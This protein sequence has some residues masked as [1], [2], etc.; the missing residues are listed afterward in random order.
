MTT[1]TVFV[2]PLVM[3]HR[4]GPLAFSLKDCVVNLLGNWVPRC[5]SRDSSDA[6]GELARGRQASRAG[7]AVPFMHPCRFCLPDQ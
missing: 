4:V 2:G 5:W 3:L 7:P 6:P 1:N